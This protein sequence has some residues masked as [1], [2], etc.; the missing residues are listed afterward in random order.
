MLKQIIFT[1]LSLLSIQGK[2]QQLLDY[3]TYKIQP[4]PVILCF[5]G[6][7]FKGYSDVLNYHYS[8]FKKIHPN[9]NDQFWNPEL[10]WTNKYKNH[11][12]LQGP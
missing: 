4:T 9:I 5:F 12:S 7:A 11:D 10:S 8:N 2:S 6:G 3:S 1:L